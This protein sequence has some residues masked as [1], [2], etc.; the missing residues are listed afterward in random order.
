MSV[1]NIYIWCLLYSVHIRIHGYSVSNLILYVRMSHVNMLVLESFNVK[2]IDKCML[3][4][5][6]TNARN[7]T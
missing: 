4:I 7:N 3:T 1:S 2:A 5:V 6:P